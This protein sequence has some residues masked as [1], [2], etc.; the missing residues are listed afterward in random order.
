MPRTRNSCR[1]SIKLVNEATY[2]AEMA[3]YHAQQAVAAVRNAEFYAQEASDS[4]YTANAALW[5][6][7]C[8]G[9]VS[10]WDKARCYTHLLPEKKGGMP[11]EDRIAQ[12]WGNV[13]KMYV[14]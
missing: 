3:Q 11:A 4:I 6:R 10:K 8:D 5:N 1:R 14:Q 13:Q 2:N 7:S 9:Y 12:Y